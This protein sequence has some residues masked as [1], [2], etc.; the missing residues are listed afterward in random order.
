MF[1]WNKKTPA[2]PLKSLGDILKYWME[3]ETA[4][5][6]CDAATVKVSSPA[7]GIIR[8]RAAKDGNFETDYSY[9]VVE[10]GANPP[11][12]EVSETDDSF[13][14]KSGGAVLNIEKKPFRVKFHDADGT[15]YAGQSNGSGGFRGDKPS[16]EM[17]APAGEIYLGLGEKTGGL[18]K[19]GK[20]WKMWATDIPYGVKADPIYQSIPVLIGQRKGRAW[21]A[22]FDNTFKSFFDLA[23]SRPDKWTWSAAGGELNV[24]FIAGPKLPDVTRR[25]MK[26]VG[27]IPM[28]PRWSL[29]YHQC[30]YS[31]KTDTEVRRIARSL[32]DLEIPCDVIHL[33]IHYMDGYRVFTFDP[34][35]FPDPKGLADELKKEGIRLVCIMDPGVKEDP[36]WDVWKDGVARDAFCKNT[37]GGIVIKYCWPL[38]AGW[39][40]FGREEVRRWWGDKHKAYVDAGIEGIWND[41]NEPS[42]WNWAFYFADMVIPP[43]IYHGEGM[44][45]T[46][47]LEP[48]PHSRCRNVYGMTEDRATREGLLRL[49]PEKRPFVITRSGYAGVGR[50]A[51]LWTGDNWSTWSHLRLTVPMLINLGL[52]GQPIAGPDTGGFAWNATAELFARWIQIGALYPFL[53]GHTMVNSRRQEPWAFGKRVE[54]ISRRFIGL[55]YKLLPYIYSLV[56]EAHRDGDP[57]WRPL[58]YHFPDDDA[59]AGIDDQVMVG[60]FLMAAPVMEK[61]ARSRKVYLPRGKWFEY[62]GGALYEGPGWFEISAPLETMPLFVKEGAVIPMGPL[63]QH[64]GEKPVDPM[65][66]LILPGE[67]KFTLTEDD[68]ESMEY[69]RGMF[70]DTPLAV[71]IAGDTVLLT[72]GPRK[73][74]Y[75]VADRSVVV[76]M[77]TDE[78]PSSITLNGKPLS[79]NEW[80]HE[81]GYV[82]VEFSHAGEEVTLACKF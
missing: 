39:P 38:R 20:K 29:G 33:D 58:S 70:A 69:E 37:E 25:Y 53:R 76:K 75:K 55:R 24:Y 32:R 63:M 49:K 6:E 12:I 13:I 60:P 66:L 21:A 28:P 52:T 65:T 7:D 8:L 74:D 59:A 46:H 35:R 40:D 78:R 2:Q 51:I 19:R 79:M 11:E 48:A 47:A 45:H 4:V 64:T 14:F 50:Y 34:K 9:A 27:G 36:G 57:I 62:F 10:N 42:M 30:R 67:G 22:F 3:G 71:K 68:G 77:R 5:L 15:L 56:W 23:A 26:L 80:E 54:E 61:K 43:S 18:D 16:W 73:G 31:Y 41:M 82:A 17:D 81:N 72:V 1:K 44:M